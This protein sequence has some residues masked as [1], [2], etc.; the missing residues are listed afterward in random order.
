MLKTFF[1]LTN[2][3]AALLLV[4]TYAI[5]YINPIDYQ[6]I[7]FLGLLYPVL[8]LVNLIYVIG[9]AFTSKTQYAALSL[10]VIIIGIRHL[11]TLVGIPYLQES[12]A[13]SKDAVKVSSY[14][15]HDFRSIA[16]KNNTFQ[17]AA[18]KKIIKHLGTADYI[19][20]QEIGAKSKNM[21]Q[22][23]LDYPYTFGKKGT[24]IFS[25]T[26]FLN[27]GFIDFGK[28]GNSC[29]WADVPFGETTVRLYSLHLESN[30]VTTNSEKI[31]KEK[32]MTIEDRVLMLKSM[33]G[34]Y[35]IH[36]R[37]RVEQT[38]QVLAHIED[39]PYPVVVCGDFNDAPLSYIYR[40]FTKKLSDGFTQQGR[41]VGISFRGY[42]PFLRIDYILAD[43]SL[44]FQDYRTVRTLKYSD[45]YPVTA[46]IK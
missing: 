41:G 46:V 45:H 6:K 30:K 13:I 42:I 4:I 16:W 9:W 29:T 20:A 40:R 25:R 22:K 38:E 15:T 23:E 10:L 12:I 8:L 35:L 33:F 2:I 24:M 31:L 19:C 32:E 44:Q 36:S 7:P 27:K 37:V 1:L 17:P 34:Q 5:P 14:N 43:A 21:L 3:V 11:L 39:S 28:T 18:V 26:P